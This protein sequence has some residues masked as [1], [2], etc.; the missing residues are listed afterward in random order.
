LV[1]LSKLPAVIRDWKS[2]KHKEHWQSI[3][4][5]RQDK[6]ILKKKPSGEGEGKKRL[7]GLLSMSR[8]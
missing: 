1:Y 4:A 7:R 6:D 8:N 3:H 5:Q 2:R